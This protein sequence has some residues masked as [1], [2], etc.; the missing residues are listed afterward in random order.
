MMD[1]IKFTLFFKSLKA[2]KSFQCLK[3]AEVTMASVYFEIFFFQ[4][5]ISELYDR[6]HLGC[7]LLVFALSVCSFCLTV[8]KR[9]IF[10]PLLCRVA[11]SCRKLQLLLGNVV[12]RRRLQRCV[13]E[14]AGGVSFVCANV[15]PSS[16][17]LLY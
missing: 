8:L 14:R 1:I 11:S 5:S 17:V 15:V 13:S 2:W 12:I 16:P 6:N 3:S 9:F 7:H 10:C 4:W